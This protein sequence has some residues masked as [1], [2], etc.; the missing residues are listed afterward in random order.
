MDQTRQDFITELEELVEQIF[1]DLEGLQQKKNSGPARR[2][3]LA[4]LLRHTHSTKGSAATIGLEQTSRLAHEFEDLC[5]AIRSGS[6][7]LSKKV[8]G[9]MDEAARLLSETLV[10]DKLMAGETDVATTIA[11]LREIRL[12]GAG[13]TGGESEI[14]SNL[15][16]EMRQSLSKSDKQHVVQALAEGNQ[17]FLV[18]TSFDVADF[19]Q[20]VH[21]LNSRLEEIGEVVST[22][23][24]LDPTQPDRIEFRTLFLI[25]RGR[26]RI[27][28]DLLEF[29]GLQITPILSNSSKEQTIGDDDEGLHAQSSAGSV[30]IE[31]AKIEALRRLSS[32]LARATSE[33]LE[34]GVKNVPNDQTKDLLQSSAERIGKKFSGIDDAIAEFLLVPAGRVLKRAERAGRAAARLTNKEILF[35][36]SGAELLLDK[37]L[38]EAMASPLVHLV[39]N[40]VDHGIESASERARLGKTQQG[41]VRVEAAKEGNQLIIRIIDDGGGIDPTLVS[42]AAAKAGLIEAGEELDME[43]SVRLIFKHGFST[44]G[45]VSTTSGRGIGLDVVKT[46]VQRIGG[47]VRVVS[48]PG[49]GTTF[50]IR[51]RG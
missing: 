28:M 22:H 20:Q 50:E 35:E 39:R 5:E 40:A 1:A 47:E 2:R 51:V 15:P 29:D 12:S 33:A 32:D 14:F 45:T 43:E 27:T 3:L 11:L 21:R 8:F 48:E 30:R 9:A 26:P 4:E 49:F 6:V 38:S 46:S 44:A 18:S 13:L 19:D 17:A 25:A 7:G 31:L 23:P 36:T 10:R 37:S 41:L 24:T 42:V 34:L 16:A